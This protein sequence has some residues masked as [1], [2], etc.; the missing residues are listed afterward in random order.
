TQGT[1]VDIGAGKEQRGFVALRHGWRATED[2]AAR[3]YVKYS[4]RD[5]S[6]LVTGGPGVD[7]TRMVQAGFRMDWDKSGNDRITLQGDAYDAALG[8]MLRPEFTLGTL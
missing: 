4:D 5:G 2:V 1:L 3:A 6:A 7:D 8:S